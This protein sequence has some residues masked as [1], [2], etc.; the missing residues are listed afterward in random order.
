MS[1]ISAGTYNPAIAVIDSLTQPVLRPF[2]RI[3]PAIGGLDIS[4]IFAII[5]LSATAM[6]ISGLKQLP[7]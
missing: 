7:I 4:P 2:R 5:L 3:I 6:L 1:W